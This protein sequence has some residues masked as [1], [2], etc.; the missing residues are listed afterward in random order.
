MPVKLASGATLGHYVVLSPLGAG[1][2]GEVYRARDTTLDRDVAIKVLPEHLRGDPDAL[3]RLRREAKALASLNHPGIAAIHELGESGGVLYAVLELVPGESLAERLRRGPLGIEAGLRIAEQVAAALEAAHEKG[4]IHRDLKPANVQVMAGDRVKLLDFG[5]AKSVEPGPPSGPTD[6]S[7]TA[8]REGTLLGTPLYMSPE[9]WRGQAV[10]RPT[11]LWAFGCVLFELMAG[12]PPFGGQTAMDISAAALTAE[13]NWSLLPQGIPEAARGLIRRCLEKDPD[14]RL[15]D[16]RDARIE[17]G[18]ALEELSSGRRPP[19]RR[20]AALAAAAVAA[21]ALGA[22]AVVFWGRGT[23][24]ARPR[25]QQVTSSEGIEQSPA[26]SPDGG[27]IAYSAERGTVRKIL[28]KMLPDGAEAV[29]TQGDSDDIRPAWSPDGGRIL[30]VR[31]AQPGKRLEPGDVFGSYTG[32]DVWEVDLKTGQERKFLDNAFDPSFSPDGKTVAVDASWVGAQRIWVVDANGHNP[33]QVSTDSSEAINHLRPR[34]SADGR[35]IAFQTQER[36]QFHIRV[37]DVATKATTLSTSGVFLDLEP[38]WSPSGRSIYFTSNRGGGFNIWR[39]PYERGSKGAQAEQLTTGAGQDLEPAPSL[40]G[41]SLAFS[42]LRQNAKLWRLPVSP[43]T[44][45]AAGPPEEV[46]ATTRE[47]SRGA[48]SPD[49]KQIAF[50]SDRTGDMNIWLSDVAGREVRQLTHGPGG[51][52]QPNWAPDGRTIAF[53]SSRAGSVDVWKVDVSSGGLTQLTSNQSVDVNPAFSPDGG[54]IAFQSD[55]DGRLEVWLM[56]ADGTAA[57]ALTH[58]GV[59]GHFLRWTRDGSGVIFRCPCGGKPV[60]MLVPADGGEPTPLASI[61]G[62]SHMSLSPDGSRIMDVVGHKVLWVSPLQGG[63]PEKV[64]EFEDQAVRIDYP[65]WSP[66]GRFVLF[67][68]FRPE[69]GDI[70]LL[71]PLE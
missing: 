12:R 3:G 41:K 18:Y 58:V 46:I 59:T 33:L 21:L 40:D 30:F 37:V 53:F 34:F 66:D 68:R 22:T 57:R 19:G 45:H 48:W 23:P 25:L 69:G 65:V 64:F 71:A 56:N 6:A 10:D 70:W 62:G 16:A 60:S 49:G 4:I 29:V 31:G 27:R 24:P 13:P 43:E 9:L 44:G 14:R 55:R 63:A 2:M 20:A 51:D 61:S 47:T 11:D 67:D 28:V 1:G 36:T 52:Y 26:W 32:G 7:P 50:N 35:S 5:L 17:I 39:I 38:V 42:I 15:R 54:R 8:T